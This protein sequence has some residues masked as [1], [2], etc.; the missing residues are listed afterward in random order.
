MRLSQHFSRKEFA[1][2]CGCG[3]DTVDVLL[4]DILERVRKYFKQPI[5]ITSG[6][7]CASHN[8]SVGGAVDSQHL[9]GKAADFKVKNVSSIEV[10][11]FVQLHAP[12]SYGLGAYTNWTHIDVRDNFA[13]WGI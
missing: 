3:Q 12:K 7:R 5:T 4:I 10:F 13:R 11:N 8:K 1:C 6:N 2:Q 9:T